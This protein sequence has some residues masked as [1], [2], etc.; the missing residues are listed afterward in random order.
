MTDKKVQGAFQRN[1]KSRTELEAESA[2]K[3]IIDSIDT[4]SILKEVQANLRRLESC[5]RHR[6]GPLGDEARSLLAKHT[7]L[8]C[9]GEI[10]H[11]EL[12]FYVRG[13]RDFGADPREIVPDWNRK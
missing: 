10:S 1:P 4:K 13:A 9:G 3:K 5:A 12:L 6:F 7:C 11:R 8:A 2:V